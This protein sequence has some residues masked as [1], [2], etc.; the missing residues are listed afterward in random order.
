MSDERRL[1]FGEVEGNDELKGR[2]GERLGQ[3]ERK[4]PETPGEW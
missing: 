1:L 3:G 4:E 2:E